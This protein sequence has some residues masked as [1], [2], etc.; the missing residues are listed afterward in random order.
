MR[1]SDNKNAKM[2][3]GENISSDNMKD[4]SSPSDANVETASLQ[5]GGSNEETIELDPDMIE[6]RFRVDRRKL[7]QMLLLEDG[8]G[9]TAEEFFLKVMEDSNVQITW[10]SKLKIGAKS[11]KDPHI[12]VMGRPEDVNQAKEQV[13]T[14]LDTKSNRVTL[15]MDVSHTEHSHVIGKGGNQ[16]KAVMQDTGCH[17]HFPDSNRSSQ[18]EKS[19]QVSIAGQPLGVEQARVKIRDLLPLVYMFELPVTGVLQPIPD[20]QSQPIQHI[21][22]TYNVTVTIKQRPKVYVTTVIVRG[23]IS[24]A[25]A[26]KEATTLLVEHL[27]GTLGGTLPVSMQ[28]EIA[29]Q[30]HLFIIG[31]GGMNIKHIMQ[32][33]GATIHFPEQTTV[34]PQRKGTV[35]LTGSIESIFQARQQLIDCL[36]LVLMFDMKEDQETIDQSRI[37][38]LMEQL[39]VFISIKPKPKQPSKSV[40]VKSIERNAPN[41]HKARRIL[42]GL[43]QDGLLL[44]N[45]NPT[46]A[47]LGLT[48]LGMF[49][50]NMLSINTANP[51]LMYNVA[52]SSPTTPPSPR[53]I[54]NLQSPR[55]A[56]TTTGAFTGVYSPMMVVTGPPPGFTQTVPT[57]SNLTNQQSQQNLYSQCN[58]G[59]NK[60]TGSNQRTP[61]SSE[62]GPS[63]TSSSVES[64]SLQSP[65]LSPCQ[66]PIDLLNKDTSN[67]N[68][69]LNNDTSNMNTLL[70][71]DVSHMNG[72][73]NNDSTSLNGP[74][75]TTSLNGPLNTTSLNGPLNTTSLNGP[76]NADSVDLRNLSSGHNYVDIVMNKKTSP[77]NSCTASDLFG[78]NKP[79]SPDLDNGGNLYNLAKHISPSNSGNGADLFG[80]AHPSQAAMMLA[81]KRPSHPS[82][83]SNTGSRSS[84]SGADSDTSSENKIS[85][86]QSTSSLFSS[87]IMP[88]ASPIMPRATNGLP[89]GLNIKPENYEHKKLLATK[90]VQKK[91]EGESR[92]PTDFW[93]GLGFSKSM[94]DSAIRDQLAN[95][96]TKYKGPTMGTMY[97]NNVGEDEDRDPWKDSKSHTPYNPP[98][99]A[100]PGEYSPRRKT[101]EYGISDTGSNLPPQTPVNST[102]TPA[103]DLAEL[104]CTLGLGKYTDLFT[105]QEIDLATFLTLSDQ[106]L[107]ELGI[108]TFG[109]RRKMLLAIADL[110]KRCS[111]F[112]VPPGANN[113]Y[114]ESRPTM[115]PPSAPPILRRIDRDIA[116]Q[117]G[118]W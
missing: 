4:L 117:S 10:P 18:G 89:P 105:Q 95:S 16:I 2:E 39:D 33:T 96:Y 75:S 98:V 67:I 27:T 83:F 37:T 101:P 114:R 50:H 79:M 118:R 63:S 116:S 110:H 85:P 44:T 31:R 74:L 11:K 112:S 103:T 62:K 108:S 56:W 49:G 78:L 113:A 104:F 66:S 84:E 102:P 97:E 43:E 36:P 51:L 115:T 53:I 32:R 58:G 19:N 106:D 42:L 87:P 59:P 107:K 64:P 13:M 57:T 52:N 92:T 68:T 82:P 38:R 1:P 25:K 80:L 100:A 17:I 35:Y 15:K 14:V 34:T 73:L 94:P 86:D 12:K 40:I 88:R 69:L 5:S 20:P 81:G 54:Q 41:L 9:E 47:S 55:T 77:S 29:P 7:E 23:Q 76:I 46:A 3:R 109:A 90:A 70:N 61:N 45:N 21:Q 111:Q 60:N 6:E 28:M 24:N 8:E 72:S 71:K 22:D 99:N 93:S 65:A 30:H 91:P 26:T 48:G